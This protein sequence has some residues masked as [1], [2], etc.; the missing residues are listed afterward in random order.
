MTGNIF[1]KVI[2]EY[3][4]FIYFTIRL[5]IFCYNFASEI[6][7]NGFFRLRAF[8]TNTIQKVVLKMEVTYVIL[9]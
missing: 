6:I 5:Y 4:A 7:E 9:I 3:I 2:Q 8:I 1:L